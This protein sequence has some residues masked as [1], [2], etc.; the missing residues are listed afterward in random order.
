[1]LLLSWNI[2]TLLKKTKILNFSQD[3]LEQNSGKIIP[4]FY[5]HLYSLTV[6]AWMSSA[7]ISLLTLHL[8]TRLLWHNNIYQA[9]FYFLWYMWSITVKKVSEQ[10]L[11]AGVFATGPRISGQGRLQKPGGKH[12]PEIAKGKGNPLHVE[13]NIIISEI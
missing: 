5:L 13:N 12:T 10:T 11:L 9:R 6:S 1:M 4:H 7:Q 3:Q 2:D 8:W